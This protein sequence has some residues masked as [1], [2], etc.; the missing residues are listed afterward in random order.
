M[1]PGIEFYSGII[2]E[3][4]EGRG[5]GEGYLSDPRASGGCIKQYVLASGAVSGTVSVETAGESGSPG[6]HQRGEK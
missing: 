5:L 2:L 3:N 4:R 1:F 6:S